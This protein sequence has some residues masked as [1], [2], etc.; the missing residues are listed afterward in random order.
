VAAS[1]VAGFWLGGIVVFGIAEHLLDKQSFETVWEGMW[2]ATQTVTTVGYGDVVPDQGVGKVVA[3]ILMI[4]GLSFFAVITGVITS[5]FVARSQ[6]EER[7]SGND[8]AIRRL[9]ELAGEVRA[10]RDE[11]ARLADRRTE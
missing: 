2:W 1:I 7:E 9:D 8:P 5:A 3:S 11:L 6:F 10:L 4:G